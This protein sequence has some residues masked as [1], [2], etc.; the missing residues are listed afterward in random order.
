MRNKILISV[1]VSTKGTIDNRMK[2]AKATFKNPSLLP[3]SQVIMA[4]RAHSVKKSNL[5]YPQ[6]AWKNT[7]MSVVQ[8]QNYFRIIYS[9]LLTSEIVSDN[10]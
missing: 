6:S 1:F 9:R 8:Q 5:H 2:S 7:D 4:Q 10:D 3:F